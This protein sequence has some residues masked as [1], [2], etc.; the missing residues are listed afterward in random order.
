MCLLCYMQNYGGF[1]HIHS[2]SY[3]GRHFI[4][5]ELSNISG[6]L[7]AHHA[8]HVSRI[9]PATSGE[10]GNGRH[11]SRRSSFAHYLERLAAILYI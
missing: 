6:S 4:T 5:Y 8:L 10:T 11:T 3:K 7:H 1:E 2:Y 9:L